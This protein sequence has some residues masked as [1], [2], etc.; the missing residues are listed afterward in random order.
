MRQVVIRGSGSYAQGL[1]REVA[2]KTGTSTNSRSAWFVGFTPQYST[3]VAM[4]EPTAKGGAQEMKGFG[5]FNSITGGSFPVRIWTQ[6][7]Q[8]A[9]QG[10]P[11]ISF[12]DPP[13]GGEFHGTPAPTRPPVV[14]T[15][16]PTGAPTPTG[17]GE[18][19]PT[20]T[21]QNPFPTRTKQP[22]PPTPRG[23]N[24]VTP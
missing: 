2:G 5:G 14:V 17:S 8:T 15:T 22:R 18:P 6:Y 11:E 4:F 12:P 20:T 9:L 1:H 3:A 10:K 21:F 23:G 13:Y 19:I 24:S 16:P 7:M